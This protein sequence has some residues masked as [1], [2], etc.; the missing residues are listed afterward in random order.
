MTA[1]LV[2]GLAL[3]AFVSAITPGPNNIML[4]TSGVNFGFRRTVPHMLGV[5]VGFLLMMLC[6]ALGAAAVFRAVPVLHD[7]L[8]VG[9][10][11]YL[12]W[13]AWRIANAGPASLSGES[14]VARPMRFLEAFW[15]QW[16]NP[17]AIAMALTAIAVYAGAADFWQGGAIVLLVFA[18]ATLFSVT[19]WT[20]FGLG[21]RPML[22]NARA[23]RVFNIV[24][25]V[26]LV[27][28]IYPMVVGE[29][30]VVP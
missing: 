20:G 28:S 4:L 24:M 29:T 2:T 23:V 22:Q 21:L 15:F 18:V 11:L 7:V 10:A 8:K 1:Q 6:V 5:I 27:V 13:L 9:G 14:Q 3:F 25:A 26:L 12:L 17:K 16:V 30:G 19:L